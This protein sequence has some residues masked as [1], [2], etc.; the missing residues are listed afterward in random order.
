[1]GLFNS[2]NNKKED[3]ANE[4]DSQKVEETP[5][6]KLPD[7]PENIFIEKEKP[8]T[9]NT[10][11][12]VVPARAGYGI[13]ELFRYLEKKKEY[14]AKGYDDALVNPDTVHFEENVEDLRNELQRI[15]KKVKMFYEDFIKEIDFHIESR[16][17]KGMI[18][19]VE[20]LKSKKDIAIRHIDEIVEIET[21]AA[22]NRGLGQ[23]LIMSYTRGFKNGLAAISY[24]SIMKK[25][26]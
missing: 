5:Q 12:E 17:R 1:M 24:H 20:E 21:D 19:I 22:N 11:S 15:I 4:L 18:D 8:E 26:F 25:D 6:Q 16:S 23:S 13:A 10:K 7:I 14:E 2:L 3:N 9:A